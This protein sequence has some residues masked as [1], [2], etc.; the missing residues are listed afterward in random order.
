MMD[1]LDGSQL[2]SLNTHTV[3]EQVKDSSKRTGNQVC[4]TLDNPNAMYKSSAL[5]KLN[6]SD[7]KNQ[8]EASE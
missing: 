7:E 3:L 2:D 1:H 5:V 4:I 8:P 6:S